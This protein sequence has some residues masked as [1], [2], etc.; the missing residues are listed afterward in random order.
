[1]KKASWIWTVFCVIVAG[2]LIWLLSTSQHYSGSN[3]IFTTD[4]QQ[5]L[6]IDA[7]SVTIEAVSANFFVLRR[8]SGETVVGTPTQKPLGWDKDEYYRV[9]PMKIRGGTWI[10]EKG[11]NITIHLSSSSDITVQETLKVEGKVGLCLLL[12]VI[13]FFIW[14]LGLKVSQK[15]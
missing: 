15:I 13:V 6:T 5:Q 3:I 11:R 14:L 12:V 1:M 8:P 9:E 10:T 4:D 2:L 7:E